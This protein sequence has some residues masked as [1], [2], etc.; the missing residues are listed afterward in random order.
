MKIRFA[1]PAALLAAVVLALPAAAPAGTVPA[2]SYHHCSAHYN[3]D[4][5]GYHIHSVA[6]EGR[7]SCHETVQ[8]ARYFI[9]HGAI[10]DHWACYQSSAVSGDSLA[11]CHRFG[12]PKYSVKFHY[13]HV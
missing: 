7:L 3:A 1:V 2:D 5:H 8:I 12:T 11:G 6:F 10:N 13:R 4:W 9:D